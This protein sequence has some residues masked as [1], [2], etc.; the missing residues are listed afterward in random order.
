[1]GATLFD[2]STQ[3]HVNDVLFDVLI[4][5]YGFYIPMN[6]L[7]MYVCKGIPPALGAKVLEWRLSIVKA[8][9]GVGVLDL[10]RDLRRGRFGL[11]FITH[12]KVYLHGV[13]TPQLLMSHCIS[14]R[15]VILGVSQLVCRLG[16]FFFFLDALAGKPEGIMDSAWNQM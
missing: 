16:P 7:C 9:E 6:P 3:W 11:T 15:I 8:E 10:D 5:F 1:M 13:H 2:N 12:K 14:H 4:L